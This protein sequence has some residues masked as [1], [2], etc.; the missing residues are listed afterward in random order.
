MAFNSFEHHKLFEKFM[1]EEESSYMIIYR[2]VEENGGYSIGCYNTKEDYEVDLKDI[3]ERD[4]I[5][6]M[7]KEKGISEIL[8]GFL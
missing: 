7:R 2:I 3:K 4:G 8:H 6:I 5:F 1:M